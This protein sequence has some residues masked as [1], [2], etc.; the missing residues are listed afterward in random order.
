MS[1]CQSDPSL[2]VV[3]DCYAL[4]QSTYMTSFEENY[5]TFVDICQMQPFLQ[6][7]HGT[8]EKCRGTEPYQGSKPPV[9]RYFV[10]AVLFIF[11]LFRQKFPSEFV[12]WSKKYDDYKPTEYTDPHLIGKDYADDE[13]VSGKENK[14]KW[15]Q[16]DNGVDR[17]SFL[18][19][20]QIDE[21]GMPL[22]PLGRTGL[23]VESS[24]FLIIFT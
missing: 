8:H 17:R 16:I 14:F 22:N 7:F 4:P 15:N 2:D 10:D 11:C 18:G 12:P 6:Q 20:Y 3:S 5:L 1:L 9:Y 19:N 21:N 13:I 24:L 23:K